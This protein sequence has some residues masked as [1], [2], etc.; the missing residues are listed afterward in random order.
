MKKIIFISLMV[1]L[2]V[3]CQ[4]QTKPLEEQIQLETTFKTSPT[5]EVEKT[6]FYVR[7]ELVPNYGMLSDYPSEKLIDWDKTTGI[8]SQEWL[9]FQLTNTELI[10]GIEIE[11][12]DLKGVEVKINESMVYFDLKKPS[13]VLTLSEAIEANEIAIRTQEDG[14]FYEIH[15]ICDLKVDEQAYKIYQEN[16][17]AREHIEK[18]SWDIEPE[19]AFETLEEIRN[20]YTVEMLESLAI[21]LDVHRLKIIDK[22]IGYPYELTGKIVSVEKRVGYDELIIDTLM[23]HNRVRIYTKDVYEPET[24]FKKVCF[25]INNDDMLEFITVQ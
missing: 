25:L 10:S 2:L 14:W 19:R 15:I 16:E 1:C 22:G 5:E 13:Q 20:T 17:E 23:D 18:Y 9:T 4:T 8:Q 11:G 7:D 21:D 12:S 6:A 24:M 3:G